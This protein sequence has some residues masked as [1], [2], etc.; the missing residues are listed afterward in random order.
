VIGPLLVI[1][2]LYT[3]AGALLIAGNMLFALLLAH[4]AELFT[5]G[6][7]RRLGARTAGDVPVRRGGR[8]AARRRA[9]QHWRNQRTLQ[10]ARLSG[11]ADSFQRAGHRPLPR[12]ATS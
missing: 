11:G 2:G 10:L 6:P 12:P 8:P 7:H 1:V 3:R 5:L 9:F 4:R